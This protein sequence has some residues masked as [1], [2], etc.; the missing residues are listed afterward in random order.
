MPSP[1][2]TVPRPPSRSLSPSRAS[3]FMSCPLRYRFRVID[4]LP[5]APSAVATRGTLVHAVLDELFGLPAGERTVEAAEAMLAPAWDQLLADEPELATL[6]P[7]GVGLEE[8]FAGARTLL[9]AYFALEDPTRLSPAA[10]ELLVE[11]ELASGLVLRG[12]IDR[13]DEAPG[14]LLRV[15][16]Y[17]TGSAPGEAFEGRALFQLKFYA[18]V[19]WRTRGIV[20]AELTLLYL[21]GRSDRLR[22]RPDAAELQAFERTLLALW[23]AIERAQTTGDWRARPSALCSWCDHQALCPA[24]GGTPPPLPEAARPAELPVER[25]DVLG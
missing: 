21:G 8:W 16:D 9:A 23:A 17:K 15:V 18:L 1:E 22:Y 19:L 14:D 6:F 20:P 5:E 2:Q 11:H 10:R 12:I 13:L 7:D 24:F 25:V 4:R 3:D